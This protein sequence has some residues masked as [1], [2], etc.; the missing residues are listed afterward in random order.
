MDRSLLTGLSLNMFYWQINKKNNNNNGRV[1][2]TYTQQ[3][4]Q[5]LPGA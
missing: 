4:L 5:V 3:K 2:W 1:K